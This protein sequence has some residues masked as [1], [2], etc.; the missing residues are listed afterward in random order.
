MIVLINGVNPG[1]GGGGDATF[2]GEG[3]PVQIF[4]HFLKITYKFT[5]IVKKNKNRPRNDRK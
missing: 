2:Y 1:W 4:P 5:F 3:W